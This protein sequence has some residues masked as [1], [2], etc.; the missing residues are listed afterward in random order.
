MM[1]ILA[2]AASTHL[3]SIFEFF[4]GTF[5]LFKKSISECLHRPFYLSLIN[6][7]IYHIGVRSLPLIIITLSAIGMV[8]TMQFGLGLQKF[9]GTLYV[10]RIV[11]VSIVR[12]L[13]PVFTG[14]MIAGR[15][16]AGIASEIG[17][18]AVTQQIDAIRALGTSP[19]KRIVVPRIIGTCIAL[20]LLTLF[21]NIVGL[22]GGIIIGK[23]D[24]NLAPS[25][26]YNKIFETVTLMDFSTGLF[27]SFV[28]A[29]VISISG[30]YYGL[31]VK[32]GTR[33]VGAATTQTVV[34]AS[35]LILVSDFFLTKIFFIWEKWN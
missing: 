17:S 19:I 27:K 18:M 23:S 9:G 2:T 14:L 20:P 33:E 25:F 13:G 10:P 22:L 1:Q 24:L 26:Y 31:R 32:G 4:G 5:I 35:I 21:A 29:L 12:E 30:C 8:M 7:Q 15:V 11:S 16:G 3:L 28:F 6:E 34:M